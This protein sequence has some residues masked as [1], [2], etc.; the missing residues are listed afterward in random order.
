MTKTNRNNLGLAATALWAFVL[1]SMTLAAAIKSE[2]FN[3]D[4]GWEGRNNHI[5]PKKVK[6]VTQDFGY[7][8]THFAGKAPGE[9][10]GTI[11]RAFV[12]AFYADKIGPK[13]L[14]DKLTGSGTFALTDSTGSA[15][16]FF[17]WFNSRQA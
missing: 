8:K 11:T 12:P 17:G 3:S 7:S 10:G 16:F 1:S 4:P 13:T 15:G 2:S 6:M 5:T 14:T 9:M